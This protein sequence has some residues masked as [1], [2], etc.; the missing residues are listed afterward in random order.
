[1][2][3][4]LLLELE[5]GDSLRSQVHLDGGLVGLVVEVPDVDAVVLRDED[6]TR[7]GRRESATSVLRAT[8]VSRAENGLFTL[9]KTDLPNGEVE[10]VDGEKQVVV[11]G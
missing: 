9:K 11:E 7:S 3:L 4:I 5:V 1:M 10:I 8:S 6:D 2:A